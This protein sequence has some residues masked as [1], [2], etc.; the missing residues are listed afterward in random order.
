MFNEGELEALL[1]GVEAVY[2]ET[3]IALDAKGRT[4]ARILKAATGRFQ[5]DGYRRTTIDDVA[6]A[7]GV[8]KGTVYTHFADKPDLLFHAIIEEKRA[9]VGPFLALLRQEGLSPA[10]RLARYL[11]LAFLAIE[12]APLSS[13][14]MQ[15]D[16]EMLLFIEEMPAERKAQLHKNQ[17]AFSGAFLSGIGAYD[18]LPD[19]ERQQRAHLVQLM[20]MNA[21]SLMDEGMFG[22]FTREQIARQLAHMVVAGV[23]RPL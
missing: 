1:R 6:R 22:G 11:E 7:A 21:A 16:H 14:L 8:A 4:R 10:E 13:R 9:L 2:R 18:T 23:G 17:G 20:M 15:G 19:D 3:E 12:Q 5:K